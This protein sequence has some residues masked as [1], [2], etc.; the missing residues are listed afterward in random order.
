MVKLRVVPMVSISPPKGR[1]TGANKINDIGQL[2]DLYVVGSIPI[3][4]S[5]PLK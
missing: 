5:K 3:A 1:G 2:P 4:R